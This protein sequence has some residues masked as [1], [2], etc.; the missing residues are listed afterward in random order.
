MRYLLVVDG[1][2]EL[3]LV[4]VERDLRVTIGE[5]F[6]PAEEVRATTAVWS[7]AGNWTAWSVDTNTVEGR[8]QLWLHDELSDSAQVLADSLTAFYLC[9]S[10]CGRFLSHLSPGPLGLEL[11]VSDVQTG[12]LH[13]IERG[14]PM[15]WSWSPDSSHLAVHVEGRV[16]IAQ[17]DG[18]EARV[19]CDDAGQFTVP[20]WLPGDSVAYAAADH[21][22]VAS[23]VDGSTRTLVEDCGPG[24]F[25]VD[26][27]GRRIAMIDDGS[28]H[29][30]LAVVDLLTGER[31][32]VL[33]DPTLA[34]F[35]SPLGGRLAALVVA[36]SDT[37]RWAIF[38]GTTVEWLT[39]FR[40]NGSWL[41]AVIPFFEQYAQSHAVW[42]E[43]GEE[44]VAVTQDADGRG[45]AIVQL[46][47]GRGPD[48]R[49]VDAEL[50]WWALG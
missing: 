48:R 25:S 41:N 16:V 30:L 8:H 7:A 28:G 42:S 32:E 3:A 21:R 40:P 13:I 10:P 23:E 20:W 5:P 29:E 34:F 37:V 6:D 31:Q 38:D 9:P 26:P 39:P 36:S 18:S 15:F 14:Q 12:S 35:W 11:A 17:R 19:A 50:A 24:R 27:D 2:G 4:D 1:A 22:L 46:V 33:T 44:L 43:N 47:D 45:E 49:L